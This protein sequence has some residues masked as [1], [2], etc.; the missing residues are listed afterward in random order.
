MI[1]ADIYPGA[2]TVMALAPFLFGATLLVIVFSFLQ[3][4]RRTRPDW[5]WNFGDRLVM[6]MGLHIAGLVLTWGWGVAVI[7]ANVTG[8]GEDLVA[9]T[10]PVAFVG[11]VLNLAG[12]VW[13][14]RILSPLWAK[15]WL[16]L[17]VSLAVLVCGAAIWVLALWS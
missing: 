14:V 7:V 10:Y 1:L 15:R 12:I 2:Q 13:K 11:G 4:E 3:Y 6:A 17:L 8:L 9:A 16:W 5:L